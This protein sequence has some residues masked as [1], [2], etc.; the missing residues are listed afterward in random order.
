M[1]IF[2]NNKL[3]F[4]LTII[5]LA[6][7]II[8]LFLKKN[9][10]KSLNNDLKKYEFL[11]QEE[12]SSIPDDEL[13]YAVMSWM[14]SKFNPDWSD[15]FEVVSSLPEPC[16]NIYSVYIIEG[17]VNNG[18][19]NQCYY[20]SSRQFTKMAESGFNSIG[21]E[22]FADITIR[23][24]T[25]YS[26]IKDDLEKYNDGSIES[27]SE[28]YKNNPLNAL[29]DEFYSMYEKEPLDKLCIDYIR[30]NSQYFGD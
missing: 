20:N 30:A 29:D 3:I 25:I 11:K 21:A 15:D 26:E 9:L 8:S 16:Q 12:I 6:I 23:A 13:I 18:G 1:Y 24:N 7:I 5:I 22:G 4:I 14:W 28:S 10:N 2:K 19:F 17:E 27:F